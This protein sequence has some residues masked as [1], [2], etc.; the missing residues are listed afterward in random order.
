MRI[1]PIAFVIVAMAIVAG[2]GSSASS[3]QA[4]STQAASP[5]APGTTAPVTTAPP[6]QASAPDPAAPPTTNPATTMVLWCG[7]V[8]NVVQIPS[9]AQWEADAN[10]V[11]NV[12]G[13]VSLVIQATVRDIESMTTPGGPFSAASNVVPLAQALCGEVRTAYEAP[14]P[15]D[16]GDYDTAMAS[17]LA[18]SQQLR[19]AVGGTAASAEEEARPSLNAGTRALDAF[20]AAI[21]A[22]PSSAPVATVTPAAAASPSTTACVVPDVVDDQEAY[23]V[24]AV[25]A[26]GLRAAVVKKAFPNG[27]GL[28]AGLV[29]ATDPVPQDE[30]CGSTVTLYVQP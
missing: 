16:L 29:W 28:P 3:S 15:V 5:Q 22:A 9:L 17:F 19:N 27:P 1:F 10:V 14:P 6:T 25:Q 2:C 8:F 24:S 11:N 7:P 21:A 4:A 26:A 20:L 13:S 18:A 12:Q 23:A 30:P